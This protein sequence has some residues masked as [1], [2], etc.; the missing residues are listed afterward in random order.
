MLSDERLDGRLAVITGGAKG[1]GYCIA[2]QLLAAGAVVALLDLDE[3]V[4][5]AAARL[6][7]QGGTVTGHVCDITDLEQVRSAIAE[8]NAAHGSIAIWVNNAGV[9][10]MGIPLETLDPRLWEVSVDVMQTA[11]FYC[12]RE[13]APQMMAAGRGAIVNIGS[14]RSFMPK[15]GGIAYCAPKAAVLMM[16][17]I[18]A[19]EW[20]SKGLRVNAVTPGGMLTPMWA[21]AVAEGQLD[22]DEYIA[23]IPM[24][25]LG[26][27]EEIARVVHF[28]VSDAASYINGTNVT[29]D[30]G[31][32]SFRA[33]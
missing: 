27:P 31:L 32:H 6:A 18:A 15:N 1:L 9:S 28:L 8:V 22:E 14:V 13:V 10:H 24:R 26:N 16:T 30:G 2:T 33:V 29:V 12:M 20:G 23:A 3:G 11:V 21:Q 5:D 7:E 25:R 19:S 4:K 17:E